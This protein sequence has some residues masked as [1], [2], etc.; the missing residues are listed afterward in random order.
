MLG[1]YKTLENSYIFCE[2][3]LVVLARLEDND[4]IT[5]LATI[6]Q[7]LGQSVLYCN[8]EKYEIEDVQLVY[9]KDKPQL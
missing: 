1:T 3:V 8:R 9:I 2:K 6:L 7:R 5:N 4:M